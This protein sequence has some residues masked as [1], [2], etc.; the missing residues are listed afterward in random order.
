MQKVA[1]FVVALLMLSSC[2]YGLR[3]GRKAQRFEL[4][5][6]IARI[7]I[8]PDVPLAVSIVNIVK[9]EENPNDLQIFCHYGS[10]LKKILKS[11]YIEEMERF[12]WNLIHQCDGQELL[13]L[14]ENPQGITCVVSIR[15]KKQLV[16]TILQKKETL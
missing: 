11:F 4:Q 9:S 8:I 5:E 2:H 12:G 16:I 10:M 15:D 3:L 14:F 7:S 1:F 6:S 13:L